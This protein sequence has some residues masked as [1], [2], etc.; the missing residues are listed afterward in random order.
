MEDPYVGKWDCRC[1]FLCWKF[2]LC[3][4]SVNAHPPERTQNWHTLFCPISTTRVPQPIRGRTATMEQHAECPVLQVLEY[5]S[6]RYTQD[7]SGSHSYNERRNLATTLNKITSVFYYFRHNFESY[8][9]CAFKFDV[10][11]KQFDLLFRRKASLSNSSS[12]NC[13]GGS[14]Q[15]P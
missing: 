1:K 8:H 7:H 6:P 15:E 4:V 11:F 5:I 12:A 2:S 13:L 9:L 10:I 14:G 3:H